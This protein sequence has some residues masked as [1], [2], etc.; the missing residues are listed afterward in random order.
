[1]TFSS[2]GAAIAD[3][4]QGA[5]PIALVA[6]VAR[7]TTESELAVGSPHSVTV[8]Y[9]GDTHF[10][11]NT[12]PVISQFVTQ[13][14]TTTVLTSSLNPTQYL[15]PTTFT[16]T[17]TAG[18]PGNGTPTGTANFTDNGATIDSCN[19]QLLTAG[20]AT[21]SVSDF[22]V[23][24]HTPEVA[25]YSGDSNYLSS[26]SNSVSQVVNKGA[27][28][29]APG[30]AATPVSTSPGQNIEIQANFYRTL[31]GSCCTTDLGGGTYDFQFSANGG[32]TWTDIAGC[33]ASDKSYTFNAYTLC[34]TTALPS[35]NITLRVVYSGDAN[36][37]GATWTD[38]TIESIR[39]VTSIGVTSSAASTVFG[40][41][42]TFTAT[43][44]SAGPGTPTG[45][46]TFFSDGTP[47]TTCTQG[48][49]PIALNGSAQAQ[50]TTSALTAGSHAI[51]VSYGGDSTFAPS[52]GSL[53]TQS[54]NQG[55]SQT[56]VTSS[57]NPTTA[58]QSTTFT[59]HV[60][61]VAP[62]IGT[63]TGSLD[64]VYNGVDV[65]G[66]TQ[67]T[68][69]GSGNASC[70]TAGLPAGVDQVTAVYAGDTNFI[71]S[72]SGAVTQIVSADST[73]STISSGQNPSVTGQAVTF[74]AT[75]TAHAPGSGTPTG[76]VT[77]F[78][79]TTAANLTCAEGTQP[80]AL[81]AGAA[82]CTSTFATVTAGDHIIAMYSGDANYQA[83]NS[84]AV[85]QVVTKASTATTV[86]ADNNPSVVG[87][88]V[89]LTAT[90][91]VNAPGT[92]IGGNPTGNVAFE[93][94]GSVISGCGSVAINSS[95]QAVCDTSFAAVNSY[96]ITVFFTDSDANYTNSDNTASP[97]VQVVD[98]A[99]TTT[100]IS[101]NENPTTY[102]DTAIFIAQVT[103]NTPGSGTPTGDVDF[104]SDGVSIPGC[105]A[106]VLNNLGDSG[107]GT[108]TLGAGSHI[109]VATYISDGNYA[110][111][112]SAD[113]TQTVVKANPG[114]S[115]GA[116]PNTVTGQATSIP[117]T[118]S[119]A[120]GGVAPTGTASY[121]SNGSAISDC[122][123]LAVTAGNA[124]CAT[125]TLTPG[126]YTIMANYSGDA[127][128]NAASSGNVTQ[129]VTKAATTTVVTSSQ[130]PSVSG[131]TI[132][133][134]ATISI[135]SPGGVTAAG[136]TGTVHFTDNGS[137]I[138]PACTTSSVSAQ[139]ATCTVVHTG[140]GVETINA[141]YSGDGNYLASDTTG[142]PLIQTINQD[143]TITTVTSSVN[144]SVVGQDVT[145]TAAV[146]AAVPG[147]G[148]P[149]GDVTF[150]DGSTPISGCSSVV[151]DGTAHA[152]CDAGAYAA[153]GTHS[154]TA[155]YFGDVNFVSSNSATFTQTVSQASSSTAVS[156]STN[157]SVFGQ[158]VTFTATVTAQ[159]PGAGTP[160]GSVQFVVDTI[161]LGAP[162]ALNG[163][164][165]AT[166]VAISALSVGTGHTVQAVYAGDTNFVGSTGTLGGGQTVNKASSSTALTSSV[167]PS[168]FSQS[169]TLT[170]TVAAVAPGAGTPSGTVTFKDGTVAVTG[171]L[172]PAT[173][174]GSGIAT[175]ATTALSAGTQSIT[176]VYSGDGNFTTSTSNTV[177]QTVGRSRGT[178]V[179]V[180]PYRVFDSR[181]SDCVQ[182]HG[183][184][185]AAS[186]QNVQITGTIDGG[187]VPSNAIAVV[188]NLTAVSGSEATY[189][190]L[191]PTGTGTLG[192]TSSLSVPAGI[193]RANLVTVQLGTSGQVTVYNGAGTIDAVMDVDGYFLP[194]TTPAVGGPGGTA[195]TFHPI[196]PIRICDTRANQGTA[197]D[198]S[199][200]A[201]NPLGAG[202]SRLIHVVGNRP[203][204]STS[205][206][207]VP[208][209]GTAAA[210]VLSLTGT[211]VSSS[212]F[213]TVYPTTAGSCG[214]PP[215]S[216]SL[217]IYAHT[218]LG[219][220]V[221]VPVDANGDICVY[222]ALGTI[223]IV[224]DI[225][226]WF[227]T[228]GETTAGAL[229]Y[230]VAPTRICDTRT[231]SPANQCTGKTISGNSTLTL[232]ALDS[233][234][235]GAPSAPVALVS[236]L[237]GVGGTLS[238]FL[239]AF[240]AGALP[241]PMTSDL[242]PAAHE[243]IA[244]LVI[245]QVSS[246]GNIEIYNSMG[247]IDVV[248]DVQGWFAP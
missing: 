33:T 21:C 42:V 120:G 232:S 149:T 101:S 60:S 70:A 167:N 164:G 247:S 59:A 180:A 81:T 23:G 98:I 9:P 24:T 218:A 112:S 148:T 246:G 4:S 198:T 155:D 208:T 14:T 173:L 22:T 83:S 105:S 18:S 72:T 31:D 118:V 157:P 156:S 215:H 82:L 90:V 116:G 152:T 162:V 56:S 3:C 107:C 213:L 154:I 203:G 196:A 224:M 236:N 78:D 128:Y 151:L 174:D 187:T 20:V 41:P 88:A 34:D 131:Q 40:N 230:P 54:V 133:Y 210:V 47:I 172:N 102:G 183:S 43:V 44:T 145:Y 126:S 37:S 50:C 68:L 144:P 228:G 206:A 11:G 175:C 32:T 89:A 188:V 201:N 137:D 153:A 129:T 243:T 39:Y 63:P 226:G 16:A 205:V 181:A 79:Q 29:P 93:S 76:T 140:I 121:L 26:V 58:G 87:Q 184:F 222:N 207:H 74:T 97:L 182:C 177:T 217:N 212:T 134:T 99:T 158:G 92:A 127:N 192:A 15:Q 100:V 114:I 132:T 49:E 242:N 30:N 17:V 147:S 136:L 122:T 46:V 27:V 7:C 111:S 240:P 62:A 245:V 117:L 13:A 86:V 227:G 178:Y 51:T 109:I 6:G 234:I 194:A 204:Q 69:D 110:G 10:L 53:P 170:A 12:S 106:N 91:S 202:A 190:T 130:N 223:D 55:A 119:A 94:Q 103:S 211:D 169:T 225:N 8:T 235:P 142:S 214:A 193:T 248:L 5:E 52:T 176:A 237:T 104:T 244:N 219:N 66:C 61:A 96:T 71:G 124:N 209:D 146:A 189:L 141:F 171:C 200:S 199:A 238:T 77:F 195:G 38:S 233:A 229:F 1:V 185:G 191:S 48:A 123:A 163:T 108:A 231:S 239:S 165:V 168:V 65:P 2:D 241:S 125:T 166:S 73:T 67:Q 64:F 115:L 80:I 28:S 216:S 197:C 85:V 159:S 95:L 19:L 221:I 143:T 36:Y 161:D 84:T 135:T 25:T 160:T 45:G 75:I 220:R 113:L 186:H 57:V 150:V 138:S 179:A 35:G 139:V